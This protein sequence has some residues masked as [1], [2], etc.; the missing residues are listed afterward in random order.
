MDGLEW[1]I[2]AIARLRLLPLLVRGINSVGGALKASCSFGFDGRDSKPRR[3]SGVL[4]REIQIQ[5]KSSLVGEKEN[6]KREK[7]ALTRASKWSNQ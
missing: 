3:K 7:S 6:M 2:N 5:R 1:K 4:E